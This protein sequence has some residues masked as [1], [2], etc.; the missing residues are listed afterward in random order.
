MKNYKPRFDHAFI[1]A[2]GYGTRMR[3]L[4]D[5]IPKPMIEV[6]GESL[7]KRAIRKL[8]ESGIQNIAVNAHYLSDIL[9]DH[10]KDEDVQILHEDTL[11]E[12]GGGIYNACQNFDTDQ[13][14]YCVSGDSWWGDNPKN[15]IIQTLDQTWDDNTDILLM[16]QNIAN[17][18]V[19][20]GVGDYCFNDDGL[21]QRALNQNGTH[22]WTSI[23]LLHPRLFDTLTAPE[24]NAPFSLL[25]LIDMAEKNQRLKA[26]E[27][28]GIWHHVS[29]TGDLNAVN[30]WA[31]DKVA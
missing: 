12:T 7:I 31:I 25:P 17:M 1:L 8:Q 13:P 26:T 2:A 16:L 29:T 27:I 21:P 11:L 5:R 23:R 19:T 18:H 10:L 20:R 14:I 6:N 9:T 4:T 15:S 28:D 22:M 30:Q 3:P 24:K